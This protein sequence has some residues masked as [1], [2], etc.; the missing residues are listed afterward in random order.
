[1][2][3]R[4]GRTAQTGVEIEEL[5][6]GDG[7][8]VTPGSIVRVRYGGYLNRGDPFQTGVECEI[9]LGR[10]DVFA[11]LRYGIVG[12]REGGRR[13]MRIG[14]HLAYGERG[15]PGVIPPDAVLILEVE[16]LEVC[17]PQPE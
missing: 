7:P 10:R 3:S 6:V 12:M 15:V 2:G 17:P 11:G 4:S 13:R 1:L 8:E 14:P 5:V 9:D 16:L